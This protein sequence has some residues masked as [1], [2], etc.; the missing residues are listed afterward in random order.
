M[1]DDQTTGGVRRFGRR[2]RKRS[3]DP[4]GPLF[5]PEDTPEESPQS[6]DD[7]API[8]EETEAAE[9]EELPEAVV[10]AP[11]IHTP[12]SKPAAV[13]T[14]PPQPKQIMANLLTVV[15]L[16]ATVGMGALVVMIAQDPYTPLNPFPPFTPLPIVITATFLPPTAT[17]PG[18]VEP[19]A[20]FTPLAVEASG[21][22]PAT[23][24][25]K[26]AH[27]E[28]V[29][30]PNA[31][32]KGCNWSSIAGTVTDKQG[33]ALD[34]YRIRVTGN[35]LNETVFSGAALTFGTGGFE[36]FLNGTPQAQTYTVQLL[37]PQSKP[38]SPAYSIATKESCDQNVAVLEFIQK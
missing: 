29:Y 22:E 36:L 11:N 4:R 37:D 12:K 20:T 27:E 28:P 23:F 13:K 10:A 9:A 30:A 2:D 7:S 3:L 15:F 25:F 24:S 32:E 8:T 6:S 31:N 33:G 14:V 38:L 5:P 34:G 26:L 17:P 16:L 19:T 35:N 1:S 18:T 21:A